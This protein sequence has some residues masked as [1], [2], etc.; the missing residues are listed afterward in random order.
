[1]VQS[2]VLK[3]RPAFDPDDVRRVAQ[4]LLEGAIMHDVE[5]GRN[6][7]NECIHCDGRVDWNE[8]DSLIRHSSDCVVLVAKDL[9]A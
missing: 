4:A 9:L 8:A 3:A 2:E 6:A 5:K 7:Y 1:M